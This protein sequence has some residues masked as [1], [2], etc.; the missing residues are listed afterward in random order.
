[1]YFGVTFRRPLRRIGWGLGFPDFASAP[2][3][4]FLRGLR[5]CFAGQP[6]CEGPGWG[7]TCWSPWKAVHQLF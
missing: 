1:M 3:G 4:L 6:T 5:P 2:E 7:C